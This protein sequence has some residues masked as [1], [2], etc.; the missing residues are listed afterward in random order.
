MKRVALMCLQWFL[1]ASLRLS[2]FLSSPL[3]FSPLLRS[4]LLS[5]SFIDL[6]L[7]SV[8][9]TYLN[10]CFIGTF[11]INIII[12][13]ILGFREVV[14]AHDISCLFCHSPP[15]PLTLSPLISKNFVSSFSFILALVSSYNK[16]WDAASG[17]VSDFQLFHCP[18]LHHFT[19]PSLVISVHAYDLCFSQKPL[20]FYKVSG[21]QGW[22]DRVVSSF[23]LMIS[24]RLAQTF[25]ALPK[26]YVGPVTRPFP[27]PLS[28][29]LPVLHCSPVDLSKSQGVHKPQISEIHEHLK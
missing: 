15:L 20:T 25:S 3:L 4:P 6:E 19:S 24:S 22:R 14:P 5:S 13:C 23:G 9:F 28:P 21:L 1:G 10:F 26:L 27:G 18:A 7:S 16:P 17:R 2:H 29:S 8:L 12:T 11:L